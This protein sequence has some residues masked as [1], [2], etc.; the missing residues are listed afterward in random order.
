MRADAG[1]DLAPTEQILTEGGDTRIVLDRKNGLNRYGCGP[2]PEPDLAAF[3]SSTAS[4]VSPAAFAAAD[5]LRQKL[6]RDGAREAAPRIYRREL[7]RLR[8][9]FTELCGLSEIEGLKTVFGA[10]GTDLHLIAAQLAAGTGERPL[11]CIMIEGA[12]TGSGVPASLGGRHFSSCTALG[13]IVPRHEIVAGSGFEVVEIASRQGDGTPRPAALIDAG[14][15]EAAAAAAAAGRHVLLIVT[16]VSKTGLVAPSPAGL[17]ELRRRF[18]G[19]ID[20]LID[21]C[22]F[23]L[24]PA[25]LRAYLER[26]FMVAVTGSKFLTGPAF[27]GV[28]LLPPALAWRFRAKAPS[29]ALGAYSSRAEWPEDWP[30]GH[31]RDTANFGLLLRLEAAL[32]ELRAFRLLDESRIAAFLSRFAEAI[33]DRLQS[34]PAFEALPVPALDR[35][36]IR[37]E[38]GDGPSWDQP[39][40]DEVQT[41]FPFLLRHADGH[42]LA[43]EQTSLIYSLLGMDAAKALGLAPGNPGYAATARLCHLGQPVPCGSRGGTSLTALRIC[44]SAR[45]A[46]E[47]VALDRDNGEQVIRSALAVLDKTR[48]LIEAL[49]R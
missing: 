20:I 29:R 6:L 15:A 1:L 4:V 49:N 18:A 44:A 32:A 43:P 42:Y 17:I 3:G 24:A 34:D 19:T 11:T 40:W 10:S 5:R 45:L 41:I 13:D 30:A 37:G 47:A 26:D 21:A 25:T 39:S 27:S 12:E 7:E 38:K 23:R 33:R 2:L 48:V 22:Q 16:D 28:L 9:E 14:F 31:L 35:A 46:V 8:R 36:P